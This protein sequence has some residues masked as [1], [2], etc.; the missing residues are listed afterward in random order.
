MATKVTKELE[1]LRDKIRYYDKKYYIEATPEISDTEYDMLMNRL[2]E[3]EA[4]NPELVTPDSPTQRISDAPVAHLEEHEHKVPM[5]S[6]DNSYDLADLEKYFQRTSDALD[7]EAVQWVG[8]YK[9][10]GVA[11]CVIY[12]DGHL[13]RGLTRGNG[14]VGSDI[15]HNVRT[16]GDVPL[17]LYGKKVPKILEVRGEIYMTNSDL[18]HL[19]EQRA[20]RGEKLFA[21]TRNLTA[22][23]I[24][25]LDP[26]DAAEKKLKMFVHGVG[27]CEGL[28]SKNHVDFLREMQ[29]Y[30]LPPTPDV[31]VFENPGAAIE[32]AQ[33]LEEHIHEYDF[34]IDGYVFKA[35]QF[36]QRERAGNTA[37]SPR[38]L[39]AYKWEKYE[40]T[41]R[42]N[43]IR[44]QVGKTGALTPVAELEPVQI[45]GTIVSRASLHNVDEIERKDIRE[46][47][48]VVVEKAGKIIPH[49]VRVELHERKKKLPKFVFP[50]HCPECGKEAV[51]VE[52]EARTI[53][54][55]FLCPAQ[56]QGRIEHFTSRNA[57]DIEG[58][59]EKLVGQLIEA[60]LANDP[61]DLYRLTEKQLL[62][63][64]RLGKKSAQNLLGQVEASKG[65]GLARLLYALSIPHLGRAGG[66]RIV[67]E[68]PTM[69]K[70]LAATKE[71]IEAIDGFGSKIAE[72][73]H[74]FLHSEYGQKA[75]RE[76]DSFGVLMESV[77][78]VEKASDALAGKIFVVTGTLFKFSRDE[79]H[80]LIKQHGGKSSTSVS[81]KT[82]YLLAGEKAGSKLAKAEKLGVAVLSEDEFEAMLG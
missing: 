69:E 42:V 5:L 80:E 48:I 35:N 55:N 7:G 71:D 18:A 19:N 20:E 52:G 11:A 61:T 41:T 16:I 54:P 24:G 62:T 50:K 34:E 58:F 31:R 81:A 27:W 38:W 57:M 46:G 77:G 49:V 73:V 70:L 53:C 29:D 14:R 60:E 36:D 79:A 33:S 76:L 12:E 68:F 44:I 75:I 17:K 56:G 37:K 4:E 39:I 15:T 67:E 32:F 72:S 78:G 64:E 65:R 2:K 59:G 82:D 21:N 43:E 22:G 47:D 3:I 10:D 25:A 26:K 28:K 9:I 6:I 1:E 30:G 63:L 23:A 66:E 8:E 51:R 13:V 40:A 74:G 45:A